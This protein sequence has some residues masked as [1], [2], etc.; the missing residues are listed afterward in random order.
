MRWKKGFALALCT[1]VLLV[2]RSF[3]NESAFTLKETVEQAL[4]VNPNLQ[5]AKSQVDE[6]YHR[7][8]TARAIPPL[9][10]T[11]QY[12]GGTSLGNFNTFTPF[13]T[14]VTLNQAF[15][16][17][18][19][20]NAAGRAGYELYQIAKAQYGETKLS[21]IQSVKDAFFTLGSAQN[22]LKVAEENLALSNKLFDLTKKKF[23]AGAAPETDLLNAQIQKAAAEQAAT[24][25]RAA[26]K[27]AKA[28]LNVLLARPSND[29]IAAEGSLEI[30]LIALDLESL[31]KISQENRPLIQSSRRAVELAHTEVS[32]AESQRYPAPSLFYI[33]DLYYKPGPIYMYGAALSLPI[34]DYGAIRNQI[35]TEEKTVE[36]KEHAL[37]NNRLTVNSIV[38]ENYENYR[39]AYENASTFKNRVLEPSEK[40][41]RAA[42]F[43]YHEGALPY[44]QLLVAEQNVKAARTQY[45]NL[46][47]AGHQALDALEAA[48]GQPLTEEAGTWNREESP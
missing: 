18:G 1:G 28:G 44:L 29:P 24:A 15:G 5:A 16:P 26:E 46:L 47:L 20:V 32:F 43:G 45:V 3:A 4:K 10:L 42:E 36:E 37:T 30:P 25:A 13:D 33:Y 6:A 11:G 12:S 48:V 31:Q 40:L 21:L 35:K 38:K 41:M 8:K 7:W 27:S 17:I 19:S 9:S 23:D 22:Q 34:F 39:A 2:Q 14:T